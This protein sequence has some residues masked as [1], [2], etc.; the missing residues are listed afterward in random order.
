[1]LTRLPVSR[2]VIRR[3]ERPVSISFREY[4]S[5][6]NKFPRT[7]GGI[8]RFAKTAPKEAP[9]PEGNGNVGTNMNSKSSNGNNLTNVNRKSPGSENT[10]ANKTSP[11]KPFSP[12]KLSKRFA[13]P[14]DHGQPQAKQNVTSKRNQNQNQNQNQKNVQHNQNHHQKQ[15]FQHRKNKK[16]PVEKMHIQLPPF[17]TVSNLATTMN[18]PLNDVLKKL[19]VLGYEDMRHNFILDKEN[20]SLIADEYNYEVS[21]SED[22]EGDLFPAAVK[23]ELLK[24]RPPVVTIMGHVDH[25]KTTILDYLRKSS[26]V[27]QEFGG[28]TQH[29][30]A[31]SVITPVSKKKITFLDTPGHAA[32]LKI[33]QR[34]AIITD[35]VILV[36]AADDSVMPQTIEA[37][38]HAKKAGVPVIV[39]I[40]K[41]DKQGV[42]VDKVLGDLAAQDID[43]EDYGGDTQTVRVSGKTGLNM[44]KL[45]EAVITLSEM[46]EFK[47]EFS[48]I[49]AEGWIIE[50][51]I[52]KGMGNI[53][54]VL[55]RR[56][57]VKNG[58][59]LVA[60]TTYCKVRGMKDE[61]GKPLKS[62]GPSTPIQVWGWK[63]LPD[64]GD[65]II[66]A[67]SESIAKKVTEVRETR[68]KEIQMTRDIESINKK[69]QEEI[70]LSKKTDMINEMKKAGLSASIT[71]EPSI[72]DCKYIIKSDV[73]GSA[74]AIKESI[75]GL[76]NEEVRSVV[77]SHE[78][79]PPTESDISLAKTLNAKILCFNIK[80]PKTIIN[81]ADQDSVIIKEHNIIY[82]LIED[83]TDELQSHL[84]PRIE[85]KTTGDVEIKDIF[86]VSVKKSKV[87]IAGC[88]VSTGSIKR[89]SRV[90]VLRAKEVVYEGTLSS[91]KRGKDDI[92]EARK[93]N[94]C[95]LAF[96]RWDKFEAGDTIEVF[97]E[98]EHQR[99]L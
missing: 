48:N 80:V 57:T 26:V 71:E 65:H 78:A 18:I 6:L 83:V 99:F 77:I 27:D 68:R 61:N 20:A 30:G 25:G 39:A 88:K 1:M 24:E 47:C 85:V 93:G 84:K 9:E 91:L 44:D 19:K 7:G 2:A 63:D 34:G 3:I 45:E 89:G 38:K 69:R 70:E 11:K 46:S 58:D 81:K 50:S 86:T 94:E 43:I 52:V 97:E 56:G 76:G 15:S 62:A 75:D 31:F 51:Q 72:I 96:E 5:F 67:K 55:V 29:I 60:G 64:S 37:I 21:I 17:I 92:Q 16:V 32:F 87:K 82:R 66:Q 36:V 98:V 49:P 12:E 22:T 42:N 13:N 10:S 53:A 8:S 4:S 35:I 54:T 28:I 79:G 41:C 59:I 95:G 73:F 40:N 90:K 74:E 33:R 23:P 14:T